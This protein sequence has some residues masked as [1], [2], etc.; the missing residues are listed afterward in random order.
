M[1]QRD[2]C[3][4]TLHAHT[5]TRLCP[6]YACRIAHA[7]ACVQNTKGKLLFP[8]LFDHLNPAGRKYVRA[9]FEDRSMYPPGV[10]VLKDPTRR[11]TSWKASDE[12]VAAVICHVAMRI[13][14]CQ[15]R[16]SM[17]ADIMHRRCM[18]TCAGSRAYM[19]LYRRHRTHAY[20]CTVLGQ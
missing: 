4:L 8:E 1:L 15:R 11:R 10:A 5:L 16:V 3:L 19:H 14:L 17:H 6:T 12:A 2:R 9:A 18:H 13:V 20:M 7:C